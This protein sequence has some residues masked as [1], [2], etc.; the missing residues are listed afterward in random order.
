MAWSSCCLCPPGLQSLDYDNS[1]NQLFLEEE[2]RIN[3]TVSL[4]LGSREPCLP[5]GL[6]AG[7]VPQPLLSAVLMPQVLVC[8]LEPET[9]GT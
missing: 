4:R 1:E 6:R 2:R 7:P 8:V 9:A 3:H 5:G